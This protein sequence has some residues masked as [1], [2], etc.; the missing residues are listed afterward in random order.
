MYKHTTVDLENFGVKKLR[1]AHT[2]TKLKHMRFLYYDNF[3][4]EYLVH[5]PSFHSAHSY[6]PN[7][8]DNTMYEAQTCTSFY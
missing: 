5:A 8:C 4:F 1:K 6:M 7:V 3:I 2:L